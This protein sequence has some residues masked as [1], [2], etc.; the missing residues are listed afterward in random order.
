LRLSWISLLTVA[1]ATYVIVCS[2]AHYA[3][4]VTCLLILLYLQSLRYLRL[5]RWKRWRWGAILARTSVLLLL[6]DTAGAVI[7]KD[8]DNFY[9]T[10]RGDVSCLTI[11]RKLEALTGKH[12]VMV[13]YTAEH[14]ITD[15]RVYD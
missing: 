3:A 14:N 12:H 15:V 5:M 10:C 13:R 1:V 2:N 8:C 7:R 4:P 6:V 9:W 11:Q